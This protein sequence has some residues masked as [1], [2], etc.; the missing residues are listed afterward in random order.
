MSITGTEHT[1]IA[2][3]KGVLKKMLTGMVPSF[4]S[5]YDPRFSFSMYVPE[6]HS[7]SGPPAPL[8]VIIH[9]TRRQTANYLTRLKKFAET[10]NCVVM[11]P[12]FP[13]GIIDPTDINN[14]KGILYEGIRFD[15]VLLSML[16]QAG[17]IW[18][19]Q[20]EKIFMHGF[21]GGGQ[22]AHR[23]FYLH[24]SRIAAISIGAP[25]RIT[26][27]SLEPEHTWPSGLADV[28]ELF[29][30]PP[31]SFDTMALTPIQMIVGEDDLDT[32]LTKLVKTPN[33]A[34]LEAG[35]TRM[36]RIKWLRD[37]WLKKGVKVDFTAVP[38][39]AH[40]GMQILGHVEAW[41]IPKIDA[42]ARE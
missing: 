22:F 30:V 21:S 39:A 12:L 41:L 2:N 24:P 20:T 3:S 28:E 33:W 1:R 8:L 42:A 35:L 4:A 26:P 34:E 38:G 23:F 9:G 31:P 27:P 29:G 40:S 14:Y 25:G 5:T 18:Q 13:A 11:C 7:F 36:G 17:R 32:S 15:L 16:D 19:L 6:D 37:A 10:H